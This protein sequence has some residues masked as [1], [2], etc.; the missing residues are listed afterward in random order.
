MEVGDVGADLFQQFFGLRVVLGLSAVGRQAQV[1]EGDGDHI[2]RRIEKGH[3]ALLEL[4]D[5]LF[6]EDQLPAV[7]R[8]VFAERSL[9]LGRVETDQYGSV[10]IRHGETVTRIVGFDQL[11][12]LRVQMLPVG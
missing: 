2:R 11:H 5:V 3:A 4:G 12:Q 1:V 9:D 6:L 7:H 10:Q 8:R